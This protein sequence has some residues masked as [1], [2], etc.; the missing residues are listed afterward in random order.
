VELTI[1][2]PTTDNVAFRIDR[3]RPKAKLASS[4][5]GFSEQ[6]WNAAPLFPVRVSFGDL[7]KLIDLSK[8]AIQ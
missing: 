8:D 2:V 1:V 5:R 7:Q 6:R 4:Y 3:L